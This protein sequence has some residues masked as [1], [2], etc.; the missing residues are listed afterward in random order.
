MDYVE[1]EKIQDIKLR[2]SVLDKIGTPNFKWELQQAVSKEANEKVLSSIVA[3]LEKFATQIKDSNGLQYVKGYYPSQGPT[4]TV[5]DD[6]DTVEYFFQIPNSGYTSYVALYK[7]YVKSEA[8][9]VQ[10]EKYKKQQ[11]CR[12]ALDGISKRAYQLRGNF[13][14]EISNA[15]AKKNMGVVIEYSL[16][17]MLDGYVDL[18][19]DEYIDFLGIEVNESEDDEDDELDFDIISEAVT[20]QPERHLLIAAYL[21][22]DSER[23]HYYDWDNRYRDNGSLNIVYNF[24]TKLGYEMS[25]EERAMRTG[26]HKL[27]ENSEVEK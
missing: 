1:L 15:I 27:F 20:A 11:E 13:I 26:T 19:L 22:L 6:A 17:A 3:E 10:D 23:E 16:R 9:A 7:K 18:G 2:N 25:D 12:A 4:V 24:L 8:S 14:R 5:P 21:M